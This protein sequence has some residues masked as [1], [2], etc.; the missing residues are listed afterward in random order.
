MA[1]APIMG[2]SKTET[3][4]ATT[5]P[6]VIR[7]LAGDDSVGGQLG[8]DQLF[9]GPG[10]DN[11][12]GGKGDD[13][14]VSEDPAMVGGGADSPDNVNYLEGESGNDKLVGGRGYDIA[15][16]WSS[17]RYYV[18][19]G[20]PRYGVKIDLRTQGQWQVIVPETGEREHLSGIDGIIGSGNNDLLNG[21][22]AYN[23]IDG[24]GGSDIIFGHGGDDVL[25]GTVTAGGLGDD[26]LAATTF[27]YEDAPCGVTV[28]L[29]ILGKP[30]NTVCAGN[31]QLQGKAYH[32][33][34]SAFN[35]V[36]TGSDA[37]TMQ[38]F[39]TINGL[40][41]DDVIDPGGGNDILDGGPG[42]DTVTY[43]RAPG[44]VVIDLR[45]ASNRP[46]GKDT[47]VNIEAVIGSNFADK[48]TCGPSPCTLTGGRGADV[49]TIRAGD[50]VTDFDAAQ[51]D[52]LVRLP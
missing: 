21:D 52:K 28:S 1:Q 12:N 40:A 8:D 36:L 6:D 38:G 39:N 14:L 50:T 45:L 29:A 5:G 46:W 10:S 3:M 37:T 19:K 47:L 30:Q 27:S 33:T 51:G 4:K 24:S 48:L 11:L 31:D 41:G 17:E 49:F 18:P 15:G 35:D 16:Y 2:T 34:G 26:W 20:S 23:E 13:T 7:A 44:P 42:F 25:S 9:G 22:D 32:L 43:A